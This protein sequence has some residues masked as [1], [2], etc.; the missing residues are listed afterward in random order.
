MEYHFVREILIL[1]NKMRRYLDK[2]NLKIGITLGQSRILKYLLS[3]LNEG[4]Y[5]KD[6]ETAFSIR[7]SS[8]NGL[9]E[10][11]LSQGYVVRSEDTLDKRKRRINLTEAGHEIALKTTEI[12]NRFDASF[13]QQIPSENYESLG[14]ILSLLDAYMNQKEQEDD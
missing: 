13:N 1:S 6:L 11:L 5:Q 4:V 10:I 3:N 14:H 7:G 8:V 9:I 12:F 2:E